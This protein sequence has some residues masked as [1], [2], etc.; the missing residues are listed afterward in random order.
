MV[1]EPVQGL[2]PSRPGGVT[3]APKS[4]T[5]LDGSRHQRLLDGEL[6]EWTLNRLPSSSRGNHT[7]NCHPKPENRQ[8]DHAAAELRGSRAIVGKPNAKSSRSSPATISAPSPG[9][10]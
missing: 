6:R 9:S 2:D 3:L 1:L 10:T 5:R 4:V 7:L 8:H